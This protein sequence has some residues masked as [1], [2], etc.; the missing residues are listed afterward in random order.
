MANIFREI[1][2]LENIDKKVKFSLLRILDKVVR[3]YIYFDSFSA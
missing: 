1:R 2:V 3:C